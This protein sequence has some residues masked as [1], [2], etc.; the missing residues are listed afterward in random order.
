M[1]ILVVNRSLPAIIEIDSIR[2][3][4]L[5][6]I[7]FVFNSR[8]E[9]TCVRQTDHRNSFSYNNTSRFSPVFGLQGHGLPPVAIINYK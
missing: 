5:A 6:V 1:F 9:A 7:S 3:S 2:L 4:L 8:H